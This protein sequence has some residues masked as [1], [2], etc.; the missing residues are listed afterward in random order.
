M[1]EKYLR[2]E[3]TNKVREKSMLDLDLMSVK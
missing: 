2:R 1:I 3:I